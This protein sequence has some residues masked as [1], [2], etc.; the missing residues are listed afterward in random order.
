MTLRH[1]RLATCLGALLWLAAGLPADAQAP[2]AVGPWQVEV[3]V[4]RQAA[5]ASP[6]LVTQVDDRS[7]EPLTAADLRLGPQVRRLAATGYGPLLHTGWR[8]A[9][10]TASALRPVADGAVPG[11]VVR[12]ALNQQAGGLYLTLD[13]SIAASG[14]DARPLRIADTRRIRGPGLQYF[15]HPGFGVLAVVR[16]LAPPAGVAPASD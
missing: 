4:F 2:G 11:L 16:S 13:V 9:A 10:G 6:G 3:V 12:S 15:D 1:P 14:S 5:T 7:P 8:Q